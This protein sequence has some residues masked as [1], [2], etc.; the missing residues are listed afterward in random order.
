MIVF[1]KKVIG[2]YRFRVRRRQD[3]MWTILG[4]ISQPQEFT[5]GIVK[6]T[7]NDTYDNIQK[8]I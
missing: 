6:V 7:V 8:E 4:D 1:F 3:K 2:L 5:N